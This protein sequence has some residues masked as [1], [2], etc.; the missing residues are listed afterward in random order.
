MSEGGRERERERESRQM[1]ERK[2]DRGG[3][4]KNIDYNGGRVK[5]LFMRVDEV[6]NKRTYK[7]IIPKIRT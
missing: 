6:N 4:G 7:Y 3:R 2:T 1:G 5:L